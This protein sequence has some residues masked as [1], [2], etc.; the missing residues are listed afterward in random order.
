MKIEEN[1][2]EE[3]HLEPR[4][5]N[6]GSRSAEDLNEAKKESDRMMLEA[7]ENLAGC[8]TEELVYTEQQYPTNVNSSCHPVE[9]GE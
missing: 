7:L 4:T 5:V 1:K 2:E 8:E 3:L 9:E 6:L